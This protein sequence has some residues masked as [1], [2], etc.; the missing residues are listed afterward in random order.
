V[1]LDKLAG[2]PIPMKGTFDYKLE[3]QS[4]GGTQNIAVDHNINVE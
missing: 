1:N 3:S 2:A 4:L